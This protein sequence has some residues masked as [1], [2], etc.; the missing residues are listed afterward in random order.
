[1]LVEIQTKLMALSFLPSVFGCKMSL[2]PV[3]FL[4][5]NLTVWHFSW[6]SWISQGLNWHGD[7]IIP[8][9]IRDL[10]QSSMWVQWW[11]SMGSFHSCCIGSLNTEDHS[12]QGYKSISEAVVLK[13]SQTHPCW[14]GEGKLDST[15]PWTAEVWVPLHKRVWHKR[16]MKPCQCFSNDKMGSIL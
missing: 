13:F 4:V 6:H 5:G 12:L 1:M 7:W 11:G 10:L 15:S 9:P 8:L 14:T 3:H 2:V 16:P